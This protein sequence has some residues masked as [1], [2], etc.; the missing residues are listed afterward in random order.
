MKAIVCERY[1]PPD[2]LEMRDIEVP[3]VTDDDV[4]V[5]VRA[6]MRFLEEGHACGKVVITV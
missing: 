3:A 4:P 1:G 6:A 2:V 5:R